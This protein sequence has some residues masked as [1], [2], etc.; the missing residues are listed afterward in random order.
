MITRRAIIE[1]QENAP[2]ISFLQVEQDLIIC[3]AL[4]A[5]F[6]DPFLSSRLA[7]RGGTAIHKLFLSPPARFSEDIDLVQIVPE[8]IGGILDKIREV[9]D[10]LGAPAVKQKKFNNTMIFKTDSVATP[11]FSIKLK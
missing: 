1:W 3:R 5:L 11:G 9:L 7:F 10:F 8:P 2:W 6:R 4:I